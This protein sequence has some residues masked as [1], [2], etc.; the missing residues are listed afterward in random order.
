[1]QLGR[2]IEAGVVG[3]AGIERRERFMSQHEG[4]LRDMLG[5]AAWAWNSSQP[6][7]AR[8]RRRP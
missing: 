6:S 5:A 8:D 2:R 3:Q 4:L 1:M 7:A